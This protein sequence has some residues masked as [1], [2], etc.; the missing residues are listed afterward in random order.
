MLSPI[1]GV[2]PVLR[3]WF[4][5]SDRGRRGAR[6]SGPLNPQPKKGGPL[7]LEFLEDRLAPAVNAG[8]GFRMPTAGE[9]SALASH[10]PATYQPTGGDTYYMQRQTHRLLAQPDGQFFGGLANFEDQWVV[11]LNGAD[12]P[13]GGVVSDVAAP[14]LANARVW[15]F[16]SDVPPVEQFN[17][18]QG[19]TNAGVV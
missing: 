9:I 13:P 7:H 16:A 4:K 2:Q 5:K 8:D 12:A 14:L 11:G 10:F 19:A 3:R 1:K 18:V 6:R 15:Q 17:R